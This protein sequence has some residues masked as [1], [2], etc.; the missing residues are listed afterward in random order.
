[1]NWTTPADLKSQVQKWWDRGELLS[2]LIAI[3]SQFPRRLR[4]KSPSSS[5]MSELFDDVR[6][7]I[8]KLKEVP[9]TRVTMREFKHRLFGKNV[10]P[11]EI[12]IDTLDDA[13][14]LIG[15]RREAN[16][17]STL[18]RMTQD[19]EP[20]LL[21]WIKRRPLHTLQLYE[22][23]DRLL[24]IAAWLQAHPNPNVYL[25]QVDVVGVDSK[26]IETHRAVLTEWLDLVLAPE[27][28]NFSV[29]GVSQFARRYGFKDKPVR[30][31][32]RV[33]DP[34]YAMLA[35][36]SEQDIT[37]DAQT[38]A[39]LNPTIS[40]VFITENEINFLSFPR[41]KDSMVIFG[42]GYGFDALAQANWLLRCQI[43]YWGDID[44]HGFAILNSARN[45][46]PHIQSFLMDENTL[47]EHIELAG[48]EFAQHGA[49][50]LFNLT[51]QEQSMYQGLKHHI[52][53]QN[54]RLEQ[55]RIGWTYACNAITQL[56]ADTAASISS[57]S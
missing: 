47:K 5:E 51:T 30:I 29:S 4:L 7:W 6:S 21:N 9:H 40:R 33:L 11:S 8:A 57:S 13:I 32:F 56:L 55:E 45:Y 46:L 34:N 1:M 14:A 50:K 44:T 20:A 3:E 49:E 28:I 10:V 43:H 39:Y 23:W 54:V 36:D 31:R 27:S 52:W 42:A 24:K 41:L 35:I 48:S 19:R 25:R 26:F 12:W 22:D 2:E 17:F 18:V 38:F 37:L 53:G 15:K 16:R